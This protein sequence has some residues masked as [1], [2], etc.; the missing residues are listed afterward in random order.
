M[1]KLSV[2]LWLSLFITPSIVQAEG[3]ATF[4]AHCARCHAPVEIERRM[5]GE[6]AGR[7]ADLLYEVTRQTMPG[8]TPG[9][10]SD[11]EYVAVVAYMLD[12]AGVTRPD[13][14]LRANQLAGIAIDASIRDEA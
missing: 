1:H 8:E 9:S 2:G 12:L 7:S 13:G 5:R 4:G 11:D 3:E 14:E 10:L 6:W